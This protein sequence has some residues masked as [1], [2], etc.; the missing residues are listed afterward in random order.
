[1]AQ[2]NQFVRALRGQ[3]AGN[4]G[5]AKDVAFPGVALAHD[6]ERRLVH[7]DATFGGCDPFGRRL[8]GDIDHAGFATSPKMGQ[9]A[10]LHG[11]CAAVA[12]ARASKARVASATSARRMRLSPIR[13]AEIPIAASRARSAGVAIPLSPTMILSR[14]ICGASRSLTARL[15]SN[16]RRSRLLL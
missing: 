16:V 1:M 4:P 6:V 7:D 12:S 13:N 11:A 5:G 2:Q 10:A 9:P 15:V 3:D 8:L 14:G